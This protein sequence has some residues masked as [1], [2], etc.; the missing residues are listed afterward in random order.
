MATRVV[1][2]ELGERSYPIYIGSGLLSDIGRLYSE[3]GESKKVVVITSLS[4]EKHYLRQVVRGLRMVGCDPLEIVLPDGEGQKTLRVADGIY[5]DMIEAGLDRGTVIIALGGGVIGDLAG[6]IAATYM[7]GV[8]LIHVPTTIVAQVDS[9]IGGKVAVDHRLGKNMIGAFHQ[10][11]FVLTD[12][13]TLRTLP[14]PEVRAGMAEVVKHGMI[15]D[16]GLFGLL[17]ERL[18]EVLDVEHVNGNFLNDLIERNCR[19]KAEVV[20]ADEREEGGLRAILNY[21]HTIGHALEAVTGYGFYRHGEAVVLGMVAAARIAAVK[22]MLSAADEHRQNALLKRLVVPEM[23]EVTD[24]Q[25]IDRMRADKK[26]REGA[27][28]FVLAE[29]IGHV[30]GVGDVTEGEIGEGLRTMREWA[31]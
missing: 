9:S 2:V 15:R 16:A 26:N 20:S 19:I 5:G 8:R 25:I 28:R 1:Q 30:R 13:D 18:E 31:E 27:I 22:G 29:R 3:R 14:G 7:R 23:A 11:M 12:T 24:E 4:V 10:P 6:F 17:E 21:G